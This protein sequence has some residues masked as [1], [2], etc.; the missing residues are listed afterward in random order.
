MWIVHRKRAEHTRLGQDWGSNRAWLLCF[1]FGALK[2]AKT[3]LRTMDDG[4]PKLN[5][6][7]CAPSIWH[8]V[9]SSLCHVSQLSVSVSKLFL[10]FLCFRSLIRK[11]PVHCH[12]SAIQQVRIGST[13]SRLLDRPMCH[14]VLGEQKLL[15]RINAVSLQGSCIGTRKSHNGSPV[16]SAHRFEKV[17]LQPDAFRAVPH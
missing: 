8:A 5:V 17:R 7:A 14:F 2:A 13:G 9:P 1:V 11:C 12:I 4:I 10:D 3:T 6:K 16:P 15:C